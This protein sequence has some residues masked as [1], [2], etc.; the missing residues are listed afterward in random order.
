M[1]PDDKAWLGQIERHATALKIALE[2]NR[3]IPGD[4]R[5]AS[6][7]IVDA[8]VRTARHAMALKPVTEAE[9]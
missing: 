8:A 4:V 7:R 3:K 9:L 2:S 1:S 6:M 5:L